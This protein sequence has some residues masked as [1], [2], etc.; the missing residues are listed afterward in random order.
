MLLLFVILRYCFSRAE[1]TRVV[2]MMTLTRGRVKA[3]YKIMSRNGRRFLF[4]E[5][6]TIIAFMKLCFEKYYA[7]HNTLV[8]LL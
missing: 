6:L 2:R 4:G 1:T 5:N 8:A 7:L 3:N